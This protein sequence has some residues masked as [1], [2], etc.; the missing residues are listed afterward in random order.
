MTR[1]RTPP[2]TS[3]AAITA[4]PA[5]NAR[6]P[7]APHSAPVPKSL[8]CPICQTTFDP[9]ASGGRCPV[10]GEQVVPAAAVTREVPG[11]SR[12]GRWL[13]SGGWRVVLVLLVVLYQIVLF[14]YLWHLFVVNH[15][16]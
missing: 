14:I 12:L 7:Q 5:A 8:P 13:K 15:L 11:L 6:S 2:P 9:R 16:L 10:C 4:P 3:S 1:P